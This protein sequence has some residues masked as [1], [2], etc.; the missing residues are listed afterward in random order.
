MAPPGRLEELTHCVRA[1]IPTKGT[2]M[3]IGVGTLVVILI[4]VLIIYLARRA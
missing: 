4:V 3:Y 2:A 1:A